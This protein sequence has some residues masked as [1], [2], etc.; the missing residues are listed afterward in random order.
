MAKC[1]E[2]LDC[3]NSYYQMAMHSDDIHIT[4]LKTPFGL[5][6]WLVMP[7][8]LWNAPTTWQ[9]FINWVLRKYIGKICNVYID[10]IAIFSNSLLEH[11]QN[12]RL[13]LQALQNAEIIISSSK[14]CLYTDEIEFLG[15]VISSLGI[16]VACSKVQKILDWPV[17]GNSTEIRAFNSVVNYIAEFIPTLT[18]RS[19]ILSSL[20]RKGVEFKSTSVEQ[21]VFD[22]IKLLA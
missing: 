22:N 21:Q 19:T 15:H 20:T 10:D 3:P 14:S 4:A 9:W 12:M 1:Y 5:F 2:K 16:E 11:H 18:K 17:P 7:Q 13:I 6:D 8:G